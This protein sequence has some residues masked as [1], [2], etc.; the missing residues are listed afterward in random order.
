MLVF[1][2]D[3]LIYSQNWEDHINHLHK[4]LQILKDNHIFAKNS[5][6]EFGKGE[7]EYLDHI[8][9]GEGVKVDPKKIQSILNWPIPQIITILRGFL[10][11]IGYYQNFVK[12]YACI[13]SP[14]TYLLKK[15]SF[16][17]SEEPNRAFEDLKT[18]MTTTLVLATPYFTKTFTVEC[19]AS[20]KELELY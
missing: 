15:C 11:L 1:F 19:D 7:L 3:I 13:A 10:G 4:F 12:N 14:L 9:S 6:C 5:K 17:W 20:G 18:A 2:D 8:I 16:K